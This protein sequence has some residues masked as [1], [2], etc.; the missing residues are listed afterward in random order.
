MGNEPSH[1]Y[2]GCATLGYRVLGVQ[3]NSPASRA[4]LVSF[5]DF[6]VG[7]NGQLLFD[8]GE[9]GD[10]EYFEDLDFVAFLKEHV[11]QEIELLVWNIKNK[12]QRFINLFPTTNWNGTG[13]LGVTI[14]M[15]DYITTEENLLRILE[16]QPDSPAQRAGLCAKN[17]YLLGTTMESFH[18]EEILGDVLY[19]N[20][21]QELEI[22]VYN[23]ETDVVRVV[24]LL[25]NLKWGGQGLLGAEVGRG[26]LHRLPQTCRKTLGTSFERKISTSDHDHFV[27]IESLKDPDNY[28]ED[29]SIA[30]DSEAD[31]TSIVSKK[32]NDLTVDTSVNG[33]SLLNIEKSEESEGDIAEAS[34]TEELND[35]AISASQSNDQNEI[36]P[37]PPDSGNIPP[38]PPDDDAIP[39]PPSDKNIPPPPAD[40]QKEASIL[41]T[42]TDEQVLSSQPL[43]FAPLPSL[44]NGMNIGNQNFDSDLPPPPISSAVEDDDVD[45]K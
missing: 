27:E 16:I 12:T 28:M 25:P 35:V 15:D 38:P 41:P 39:P 24:T 33:E 1:E 10:S 9:S 14:R 18:T 20:E 2:D 19:E 22:Y 6:L 43:Q 42:N 23:T 17:D 37:P 7:V 26:Y 30:T 21:D 11:D 29:D 4:G 40:E 31:E 13:L 32:S 8:N 36:P 34:K 45:L 44:G 5:F 3:P